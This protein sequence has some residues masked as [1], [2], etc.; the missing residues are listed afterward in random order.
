[1]VL[2]A[3]EETRTLDL[4]ITSAPLYTLDQA[5]QSYLVDC[6]ARNLRPATITT[7]RAQLKF[8][9]TFAHALNVTRIEDV[10]IDV[11]R[12]YFA[13]C[14][15]RGLSAASVRTAARTLRIFLAWSTAEG[16]IEA[17]PLHRLK[18][19]KLDA[20]N[21]DSFTVDEIRK[22]LAATDSSRDEALVLFWLDTGARLGETA[23]L[24]VG[25]VDLVTGRVSLRTQTKSRR[26]RSVFLGERARQA[27]KA[28]LTEHP[29]GE[30]DSL[31]RKHPERGGGKLQPQGLQQIVE[32]LG[33]RAGVQPCAPHKFRRTFALWSLRAGIDVESLRRLMGHSTDELLKYYISLN[34]EDLRAAHSAH[35][36]VDRVLG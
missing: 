17:L 22:L 18:L 26:P 28:Y 19:P 7:Y 24:C 36:A 16:L 34:D 32:R 4:R 33:Q 27:M 30:K 12:A 6:A 20:P 1:M 23:A 31:W 13:D 14:L 35:G 10:S 8:F 2:R 29:A 25:N 11:L 5:I 9:T 21:P 3:V 15:Q